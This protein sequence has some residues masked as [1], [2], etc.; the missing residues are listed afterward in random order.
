MLPLG[1]RDGAILRKGVA[2]HRFARHLRPNDGVRIMVL[3][4]LSSRAR[5]ESACECV[6][7]MYGTTEDKRRAIM[8]SVQIGT[9]C[10]K[11]EES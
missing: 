5:L 6:L 10:H 3:L 8:G 4:D 2:V 11:D 9:L 7:H 1:A